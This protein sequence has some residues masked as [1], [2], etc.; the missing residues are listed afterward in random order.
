MHSVKESDKERKDKASSGS[1]QYLHE[2]GDAFVK[3]WDE[4]IDWEKRTINEGSFFLDTL[5]KRGIK[6][7]LDVATGTGFHSVRL[8]K[9][10]FKVVSADGSA[11]MLIQA[12]SNALEKGYV[13][14]TVH[15]DWRWLSQDIQGE[16]DAI[17]CLGNS[18]THLF[19]EKDRRRVLSEFYSKL[20]PNGTLI[21]DQR[22]YDTILDHG[23]ISKHKY[24]YCGQD[25]VAKPI[26]IRDDSVRFEYRFSDQSVFHLDMFPLRKDYMLKLLY[27]AGFGKVETFGD[28][29]ETFREEEPDFFIHIADKALE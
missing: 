13:L 14:N 16:Y 26:E 9:E 23:Y 24:Y 27:E 8:L 20:R 10:G 3:K 11:N 12:F 1:D 22:N 19:Y 21:L 2:Y 5:K 6:D 28:F 29:Q 17:I 15:T 18:F 4:L 7:I 25:V